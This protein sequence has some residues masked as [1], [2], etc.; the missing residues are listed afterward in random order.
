MRMNDEMSSKD[1]RPYKSIQS[2]LNIVII[3]QNKFL[4]KSIS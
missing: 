1:Y 2:I 3:A 4:N